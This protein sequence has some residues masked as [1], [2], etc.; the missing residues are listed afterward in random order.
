M[1]NLDRIE[2]VVESQ[3]EWVDVRMLLADVISDVAGVG[4]NF[5]QRRLGKPGALP[6]DR[7]DVP[8]GLCTGS[9]VLTT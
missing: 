4:Q 6:A 3:Q 5:G 9:H 8:D 7:P 1:W 2:G